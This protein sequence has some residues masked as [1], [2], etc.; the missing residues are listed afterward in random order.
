[1]SAPA[2]P[3]YVP[4]SGLVDAIKPGQ[5]ERR[6]WPVQLPSSKLDELLDEREKKANARRFTG[7]PI[8]GFGALA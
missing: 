8:T 4:C 6:F 3:V 5:A 7:D 2:A 1:V